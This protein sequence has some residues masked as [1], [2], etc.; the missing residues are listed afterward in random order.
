MVVV[1]VVGVVLA[2]V[3]APVE[4][5]EIDT[6]AVE[7][8][9]EAETVKLG[10]TTAISLVTGR[11]TVLLNSIVGNVTLA[12]KQG[13]NREIAPAV[14]A[15]H[16]LVVDV[17]AAPADA[18]H[19]VEEDAAHAVEEEIVAD[20]RL[21]KSSAAAL[22]GVGALKERAAALSTTVQKEVVALK[23]PAAVVAQKRAVAVAPA[24]K[25][26]AAAAVLALKRLVV[27]VAPK[28]VAAAA[29]A[30][31]RTTCQSLMM[32]PARIR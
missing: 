11:A 29:S 28:E 23:K 10:A 12:E 20:L 7:T 32:H 17:L 21:L 6:A 27:V 18:A 8:V 19:A 5:A 14:A 2:L 31:R 15:A 22:E 1:A 16:H 9:V 13:I 4:E 24:L 3:L 30:Q 26:L 25:K